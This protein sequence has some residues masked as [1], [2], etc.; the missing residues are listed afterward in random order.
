[1]GQVVDHFKIG[2]GGS[3]NPPGSATHRLIFGNVK[4][5]CIPRIDSTML[6]Y[7]YSKRKE[8]QKDALMT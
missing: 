4:Q 2:R 1:M 5:V 8:H 6:I 7:D 3:S